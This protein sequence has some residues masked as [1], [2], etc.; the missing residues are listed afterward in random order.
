MAAHQPFGLPCVRP[1]AGA[2]LATQRERDEGER[3][4]VT[5]SL[6]EAGLL[7]IVQSFSSGF[8]ACPL[9]NEEEN[10]FQGF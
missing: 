9:S 7:G 1:D 5:S 8:Q 6:T 10:N 2:Y 4:Q 3:Q